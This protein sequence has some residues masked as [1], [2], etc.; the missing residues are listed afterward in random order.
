MLVYIYNVIHYIY[1]YYLLQ[2]AGGLVFYIF[3]AWLSVSKNFQVNYLG[4][5]Q[6][7]CL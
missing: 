1:I 2:E 6:N 3:D 4:I 7:E 5:Q